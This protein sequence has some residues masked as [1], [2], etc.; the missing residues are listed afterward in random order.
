M[1]LYLRNRDE[2]YIIDLEQVLYFE[3]EDHYAHIYYASGYNT[4]IPFSLST[5]ETHLESY[6]HIIRAGRG[7]IINTK[8]IFR[9]N[10]I[11]QSI[12]F[13]NKAPQEK[14]NQSEKSI[15][16]PRDVIKDILQKLNELQS[17][18]QNTSGT[19]N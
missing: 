11:K 2:L 3:A 15:K 19:G 16:L 10:R 5:I 17:Y 8:H 1:K 14:P 7:Y 12:T 13:L 6:P 18:N 9:L 4:M